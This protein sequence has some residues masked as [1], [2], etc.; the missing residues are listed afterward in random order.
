MLSI[1]WQAFDLSETKK[2]NN[3]EF[4]VHHVL[5]VGSRNELMPTYL[6]CICVI[7]DWGLPLNIFQDAP[8][9]QNFG[10]FHKKKHW[11]E[12]PWAGLWAAKQQ[13]TIRDSVRYFKNLKLGIPEEPTKLLCLSELLSCLPP[14]S[15][16][17]WLLC[18]HCLAWR[19]LKLYTPVKAK[20][21]W[22]TLLLR[23]KMD[24]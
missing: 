1:P 12:V 23:T 2:C 8:I 15:V 17:R 19:E 9:E 6:G 24:V 21:N 22:P 10:N 16:W 7:V 11:L 13:R 18:Q 20:R 3:I 4:C 14:L 5:I